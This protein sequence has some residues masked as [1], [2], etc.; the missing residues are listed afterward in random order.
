[1][2]KLTNIKVIKGLGGGNPSVL[3]H[4]WKEREREE[5]PAKMRDLFPL[6]SFM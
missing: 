5:L 3:P 2:V 6:K 1:M 4:S